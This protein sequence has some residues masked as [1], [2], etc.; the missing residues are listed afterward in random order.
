M[1]VAGYES[2]SLFRVVVYVILNPLFNRNERIA[3]DLFC[4]MRYWH[5]FDELFRS[6]FRTE[7]GVKLE[8]TAIDRLFVSLLQET[9]LSNVTMLKACLCVTEF[10]GYLDL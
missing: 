2:L 8:Q 1:F 9:V 4:K 3:R 5:I 10:K 6:L 7:P